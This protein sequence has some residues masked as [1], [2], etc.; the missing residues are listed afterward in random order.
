L[1]LTLAGQGYTSDYQA[2]VGFIGQINTNPWDLLIR[3]DSEP[4]QSARLISWSLT[5]VFIEL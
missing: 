1:N 5:S 3:H 4:R 2:E